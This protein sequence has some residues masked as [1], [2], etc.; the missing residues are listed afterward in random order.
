MS[1]FIYFRFYFLSRSFLQKP[2]IIYSFSTLLTIVYHANDDDHRFPQ[3]D[4]NSTTDDF[5]LYYRFYFLRQS[6]QNFVYKLKHFW[7]LWAWIWYHDHHP[8]TRY[9]QDVASCKNQLHISRHSEVTM[10]KTFLHTRLRTSSVPLTAIGKNIKAVSNKKHW[11]LPLQKYALPCRHPPAL[12]FL[13]LR[14]R[15]AFSSVARQQQ[16]WKEQRLGYPRSAS[17]SR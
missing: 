13:A 15:P 9:H 6:V 4:C 8:F 14:T 10:W 2:Y 17:T 12:L 3:S 7:L 16:E 11:V 5:W 1:P